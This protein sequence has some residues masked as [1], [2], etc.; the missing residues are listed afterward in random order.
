ME[1]K[2]APVIEKMLLAIE[3]VD[4][5]DIQTIVEAFEYC[6]QSLIEIGDLLARMP[7]R[8]DPQ[9]FYHDIRPVLT[10]TQ[11]M[12]ASG[13]PR[14]V[15]YDEGDGKGSWRKYRGP[16][17]GQSSLL[18]C[19]D[20]F[21]GVNHDR[22]EGFHDEMR[23]YMPG[24]HARFLADFEAIANI[25]QY[26]E[27]HQDNAV[28]LDAYNKTVAG[29]SEMRNKHMQ[30]VA[31]YIILPSRQGMRKEDTGR[32]NLATL[33]SQK[34]AGESSTQ[35]LIGTGGTTLIPFLRTARDE[36]NEASVAR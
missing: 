34:P 12:E 17:N 21:L 18:Q 3:A 19:F 8:I 36:T 20:A 6:Q 23:R 11:N 27:R 15:F 7:E 31:R 5:D 33:S 16:S 30:L 4:H 28:L 32:K 26:V 10:G 22:C 29:L 13:L 2:A 35:E 24:P 14:G 9:T 25:R 1:P